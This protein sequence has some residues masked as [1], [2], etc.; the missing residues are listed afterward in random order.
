MKKETAV[1][2][3][4]LS[5]AVL[6]VAINMVLLTKQNA[7]LSG[8]EENVNS[9]R[10]GIQSEMSE[11]TGF[12]EALQDQS[13]WW[14]PGELEVVETG[15]EQS[16]I[17]IEWYLK[18]YRAGSDIFINYRRLG[19]EKYT[20]LEVAENS[21]GHCS[22]QLTLPIIPEP[23]WSH[24]LS[25]HSGLAGSPEEMFNEAVADNSPWQYEY[26]ISLADGETVR[27]G[28]VEEIYLDKLACSYYSIL[29]SHIDIEKDNISVFI[30]ETQYGPPR[31]T[32]TGARL[33][34]LKGSRVVQQ[35]PL[36]KG[37]RP[38]ESTDWQAD[39]GYKAAGGCDAACLVVTFSDGKSFQQQI[40]LNN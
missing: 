7:H 36:E 25:R 9:I 34:L 8:L 23:Q 1:I 38:D 27:T 21:R 19:E 5:A 12:I 37:A 24:S 10:S 2:T 30:L 40:D 15:P 17:K 33:E 4:L 39:A 14:E 6:L 3:L 18:D 28:S 11:V 32:V 13:A 26:Y 29:D 20:S 31:Y 35:L 16:T 22:I